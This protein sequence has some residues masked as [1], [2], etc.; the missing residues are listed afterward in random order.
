[1][2][3]LHDE[4]AGYG[5]GGADREVVEPL[6]GRQAPRGRFQDH[7]GD[8]ARGGGGGAEQPHRHDDRDERGGEL[9][10]A[11]LHVQPMA[12]QRQ[13]EQQRDQAQGL[14]FG[15]AREHGG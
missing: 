12:A 15:G 7:R 10:A 11:D 4:P 9:P 3:E 1:F 6:G 2:E 8:P 5:D 14:P 13:R